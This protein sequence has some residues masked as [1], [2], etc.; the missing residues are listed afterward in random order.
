MFT[1]NLQNIKNNFFSGIS[2]LFPGY[3]AFVMA[4]GIVSI[5][6]FFLNIV[7]IPELL[8]NINKIAY[9][10]LWILFLTRLFCYFPNIVTDLTNHSRGPGF[11]TVVAGTCV[12][13]AQFVLLEKNYEVGIFLWILGFILWVLIMYVFFTAVI[14][15]EAKPTLEQGI[16][17]AWLIAVVATQS[18]SVLGIRIGSYFKYRQEEILFSSLFMFLLGC[19]LYILIISLIFYRFTFMSLTVEA[20]TPPYWINMGAIAITTLAGSLIILNAKSWEFLQDIVP[21]LK[22]FTL[23]FWVTGTWWIP[24]LLILGVWKHLYKRFPFTYDPQYWGMVFPLG[25][26]TTCTFKLAEATGLNFLFVI[27]KYFIYLALFAWCVTFVGLV[28]SI[29]SSLVKTNP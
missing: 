7:I 12:L 19:M 23:F 11:F 28:Y 8:F 27:P 1:L 20:L 6:S 5:A 13:G 25:M 26:Y 16:N 22:G 9:L 15:H 14:L 24:L 29:V 2:N 18:I 10:I 3:F 17:G 4:T 21:F